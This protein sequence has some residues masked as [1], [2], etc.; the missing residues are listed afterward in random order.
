MRSGCRLIKLQQTTGAT[1]GRPCK[2]D[3]DI[4]TNKKKKVLSVITACVVIAV[5][6]IVIILN[7][8]VRCLKIQS[9]NI[10]IT[11]SIYSE[12]SALESFFLPAFMGQTYD[13][14]IVVKK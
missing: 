1:N 9:D 5:M 11:I 2:N 14:K 7:M 6:V 12:E 4:M 13:Y 3:G 10:P 8:P